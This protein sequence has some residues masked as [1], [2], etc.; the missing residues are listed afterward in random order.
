M[1]FF[2]F[3]RHLNFKTVRHLI[4]SILR[5]RLTG[6]AAEMAYNNA[7]AMFP[8]LIGLLTLIGTLQISP[9]RLSP[10]TQEWLQVAPPEIVT[11]ISGFLAQI[12]L[13]NSEEVFSISFAI[14]IWTASSAI[15]VAITAMDEIH[16]IP[17]SQRRP[18][19][20]SR[21]VA[22]LL[23]IGT[24][25]SLLGAS[26]LVFLSDLTVRFLTSRFTI[27]QIDIWETWLSLRW[28]IAFS[29]LVFGFGM[30]YRFGPSRWQVRM[31]LLP[32]AVAG[33]ALWVIISLGFRIYISYFGSRL[34]LTYGTLSAGILLLLWLNLSSLALLIGAQLNVTLTEA[35]TEARLEAARL[36]AARLEEGRR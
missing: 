13:E 12:Q 19:W 28:L 23:T 7:L 11:L 8:A 31:S 6:L 21:L 14:T 30:L 9:E 29:I 15:G 3:L 1:R 17:H 4:Q 32:G 35:V 34:N 25:T 22:I 24:V 26:F 33:A 27:P 18:F 2:R 10:I 5:R 36:E 20:Q 16:Q